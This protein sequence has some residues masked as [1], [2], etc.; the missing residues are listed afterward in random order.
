M[1]M[2]SPQTGHASSG[3]GRLVVILGAAESG[4]GAA[5]LARKQGFDVFVSDA[6]SIAGK[7]KEQLN[8]YGIAFE[9]GKHTEEKILNAA[10][11]IK[12]P[13]IPDKV[14]IVQKALQKNIPVISEIEFAGRYTNAR[15]F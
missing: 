14:S 6:G 13:G 7:Y 8:K 4:V 12:S 15:G 9:E 1:K 11:V 5:V 2:S 3:S 10:Q